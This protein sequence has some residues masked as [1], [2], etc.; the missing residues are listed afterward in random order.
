MSPNVQANGRVE[1]K[2]AT[3]EHVDAAEAKIWLQRHKYFSLVPRSLSKMHK[4]H[5]L[6][7]YRPGNETILAAAT[8]FG[9]ELYK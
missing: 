1:T 5:R 6:E 3:R 9:A 4:V 7:A 2:A 8:K